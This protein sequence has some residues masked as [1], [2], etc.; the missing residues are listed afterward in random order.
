MK[1]EAVIFDLFGTLV[2]NYSR[3]EYE[4]M[5]VRMAS[6]LSAP[7]DEF[8][9]LW[10]DTSTQRGIGVFRSLEANIEY[11]CREFKVHVSDAQ[12]KEVT[13]VRFNFV[14]RWMRPRPSSVEVL[15]HLKSQGYK[16]GLISDCSMDTPTVWG[17]TP[18]APLVDV[19]V[20]S[21]L[22]GMMKPDPRIYQIATAQLGVEPQRCVYIGDGS[23]QELTGASR[24]GMHPVLIRVPD[25]DITDAHQID[26]E[27]WD[28]PVV[29]SLREVLTL[30]GGLQKE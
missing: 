12:V 4:S 20:F 6:I 28:G 13:R 27:E 5:M 11:I 30:V 26:R 24:V 18:F 2:D 17:D 3:R 23:S 8:I 10:L 19:T 22:V 15:S 9:R 21:C 25:E 16:I 14:G 29:S 7:P 1:Y